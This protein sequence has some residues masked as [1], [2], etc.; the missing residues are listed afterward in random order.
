MNIVLLIVLSLIEMS[1]IYTFPNGFKTFKDISSLPINTFAHWNVEN[2]HISEWFKDISSLPIN[3]WFPF[4]NSRRI[5]EFSDMR[6]R[7]YQIR[8]KAIAIKEPYEN[9]FQFVTKLAKKLIASVAWWVNNVWLKI[10]RFSNLRK[11]LH[12]GKCIKFPK[13]SI[14]T[15]WRIFASLPIFF[16]KKLPIPQ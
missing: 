7:Q 14:L 2:L 12:F 9:D 6:F 13:R 3:T 16:R 10:F 1:K 8:S 5:N 15:K 11:R 4:H